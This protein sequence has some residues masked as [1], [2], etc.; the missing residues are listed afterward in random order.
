MS[1]GIGSTQILGRGRIETLADGVFAIAMTLLVLQFKVPDLEPEEMDRLFDWLF[2]LGPKISAYVISFM[3]CGVFWVAHHVQMNYVYRSD[4]IFMW[5][6]IVFLM[7]ISAIPFSAALIGEYHESPV[8]IRIYCCNLML[9][10][11][12]LY[13]QKLYAEGPG[14]LVDREIDPDF[15]RIAGER[16]LV[17]PVIYA[18]AAI[19]AERWHLLSHA[20]CALVPTLYI[21]PGRIDRFWKEGH[22]S[23]QST[24]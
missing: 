5:M 16:L 19:S 15:L 2:D 9:A 7:V 17:G 21:M 13:F 22:M 1:G 20:L 24:K 6:N 10:F 11:M 14:R 4:R 23:R 12:I 8:T 3:T 18:I